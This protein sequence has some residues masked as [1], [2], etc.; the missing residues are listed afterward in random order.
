MLLAFS[1][2]KG[3]FAPERERGVGDRD[4]EREI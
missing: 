4:R 1:T 2:G 3:P